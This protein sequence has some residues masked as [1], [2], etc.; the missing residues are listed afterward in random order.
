[1]YLVFGFFPPFFL[2]SSFGQKEQADHKVFVESI[3]SADSLWTTERT[4]LT[5]F[6]VT[7]KEKMMAF[8]IQTTV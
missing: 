4:Y 7:R 6:T 3:S 1:M 5:H 2:S 8:R